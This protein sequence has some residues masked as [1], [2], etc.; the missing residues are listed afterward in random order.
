M[1]N[2]IT[3]MEVLAESINLLQI[4]FDRYTYQ[5]LFGDF[6]VKNKNDIS[7]NVSAKDKVLKT[8]DSYNQRCD[9][10]IKKCRKLS[11]YSVLE[12]IKSSS[13]LKTFIAYHDETSMPELLKSKRH[14]TVWNKYLH[15]FELTHDDSL[16]SACSDFIILWNNLYD[17]VL[18]KKLE[19]LDKLN[20][21]WDNAVAKLDNIDQI[22]FGGQRE[23]S[24]SRKFSPVMAEKMYTSLIKGG[25]IDSAT[26]LDDF[27]AVFSLPH[28]R[29]SMKP[30]KWIKLTKGVKNKRINKS[31]LID[32]L[33]LLEYTQEEI[34]G[35]EGSKYKKLNSCFEIK[36]NY[37]RANDFSVEMKEGGSDQF[38]NVKSEYHEELKNMLREIG[39]LH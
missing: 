39:F 23:Y 5:I 9:E 22:I 16:V 36:D 24:F 15:F 27:C 14:S 20:V 6:L 18:E 25:F 12:D 2:L 28:G 8:F 29:T 32:F 13:F 4:P 1:K 11:S 3:Y 17:E 21:L 33:T 38:L 30:I 10:L 35:K 34:I 26:S 19:L 31:A 37:F 7:K